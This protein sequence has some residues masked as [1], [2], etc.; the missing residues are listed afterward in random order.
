MNSVLDIIVWDVQH[1]SAA[2]VKTPGGKH[3]AID[4]GTGSYGYSDKDFS[5]LC[6]LRGRYGVHQLDAIIITHPHRDHIDDIHYF[7]VLAPKVLMAP[8][9]L[10]DSDIFGG[11]APESR[12]IIEKYIEIRKKYNVD[13]PWESGNNPFSAANNG[14]VNIRCFIPVTCARS[15][16]NNHSVVAVLEYA[17]HK[18]IIPGDNENASW[19]ELLSGSDFKKAIQE[20]TLFVAPHHGR[21]SGFSSDLFQCIKPYL[22]IISDGAYCDTSATSRYSEKSRGWNVKKRSGGSEKRSC[23]TTRK[24]GVVHISLEHGADG[25]S[26]MEASID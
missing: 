5:P 13:I 21:E 7:D 25:Q 12:H 1:G 17:N 24:D 11:N 19:S 23:V 22:T 2:Y 26:Y 16:L 3:I 8:K 4:L 6:H 9:H 20:T 15:N 14:G 10:Q 18:I